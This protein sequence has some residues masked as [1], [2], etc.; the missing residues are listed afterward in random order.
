MLNRFKV[1]IKKFSSMRT[2]I[3]LSYVL[4]IFSSAVASTSVIRHL[5]YL[6]MEERIEQEVQRVS[7]EFKKYVRE[8]NTSNSLQVGSD[9]A[10]LFD[11]FIAREVK[12][13]KYYVLLTKNRVYQTSNRQLPPTFKIDRQRL[14]EWRKIEREEEG[15]VELSPTSIVYY[16]AIPLTMLDSSKGLFIVLFDA[17]G[18]CEEINQAVGVV[19]Q[20]MSF[21]L[22]IALLLATIYTTKIL[23]RIELLTAAARSLDNTEITRYIPVSG[24]MK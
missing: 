19:I 3:L 17:T 2:Q 21:S 6:Q 5:M 10:R 15:E 4:L 23:R 8:I 14:D 11:S 1:W 12:N 16:Q 9:P 7:G 22:S 20:V 24:M 13:D 18:E